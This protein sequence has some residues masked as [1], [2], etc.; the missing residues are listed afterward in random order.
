MSMMQEI[1]KELESFPGNAGFY[2]EDLTTGETAEY[3]GDMMMNA[4]SVIKVPV[5]VEL[6]RQI[7]A[8][9]AKADEL[10]EVRDADRVPICGVLTLMHT[11]L[12]VT[13][14]DL[15]YLMITISDN[16]ATNLLI[17]RLGIENINN[18][19]RHLGIEKTVLE[20]KLFEKRPEFAGKSNKICAGEMGRLMAAMYRGQIISKAA[21]DAMLEILSCQQLNNKIPLLLPLDFQVAHKTGEVD[22][23]SHDVGIVYAEKPFVVAFTS[24]EVDAGQYNC[25]IAAISKRLFDAH[26]GEGVCEEA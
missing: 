19:M 20:R 6:F 16:M 5:M 15:C 17:E 11:G 7:E 25:L 18:T 26:G 4:A 23:V 21:S 3:N 24:S 9:L 14:L 2:Y 22:G 13:L 8:G 10:V 12:Q 1:L